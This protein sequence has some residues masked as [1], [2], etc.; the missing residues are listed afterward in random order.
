METDS[1]T[2]EEEQSHGI[3]TVK[4]TVCRMNVVRFTTQIAHIMVAL[5][6]CQMQINSRLQWPVE[7]N[8]CN[9]RKCVNVI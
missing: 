4:Q 3:L 8:E 9:E 6:G 7:R 5:C 1:G 2:V